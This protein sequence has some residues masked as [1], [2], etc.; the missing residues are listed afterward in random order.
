VRN[1]SSHELSAPH[2]CRASSLRRAHRDGNR[3][4][5]N[6]PP[7]ALRH[8]AAAGGR[9]GVPRS[10]F[11]G[12]ASR[13][14]PPTGHF[15]RGVGQEVWTQADATSTSACF[16][17][18]SSNLRAWLGY[19]YDVVTASDGIEG[20]EELTDYP[21]TRIKSERASPTCPPT[22]PQVRSG[23]YWTGP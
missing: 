22:C 19:E 18:A 6:Q 17:C 20:L 3:V 9:D 5:R 16:L 13:T 4:P 2:S 11:P 12:H 14:D 21:L 23:R 10:P 15:R 1:A 7:P 8:P